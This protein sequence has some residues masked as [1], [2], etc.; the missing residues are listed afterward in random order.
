MQE[1]K[2]HRL[3]PAPLEIPFDPPMCENRAGEPAENSRGG[4]AKIQA[5][6][7]FLVCRTQARPPLAPH[8]RPV[9][10]LAFGN[11]AAADARRGRD[12][13]LRTIP[14]DLSE[15]ASAGA[16]E[17]RSRA[18]ELGGPRLLQPREKF[19]ARGEGNCLAACGRFSA[20]I[21]SG[22]GASGHRTLHRGGGPEH[23]LWRAARGAG[24]K[25]RAR[26]RADRRSARRFARARACG[27]NSR[28]PRRICSLETL[29]A[30]GTRP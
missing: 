17:N 9:P 29:P 25:R 18:G 28:P 10:H 14:R 23:C 2:L 5:A 15:C 3:K 16:R 13:L 27:G 12:S 8:A 11:H 4:I 19:A 6:H 30:T 24:R 20:R 21:R 22:A 1:P 26:A 7:A